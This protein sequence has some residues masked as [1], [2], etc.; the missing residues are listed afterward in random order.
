VTLAEARRLSVAFGAQLAVDGVD[1]EVGRGEVVGLLG[2]N[3]AGKTTLIRALLGL[4]RPSGGVAGLFGSPPTRAARRR[5]GYV[6]QHL[7]LYA[8]LSV[9]ENWAFVGAV[10]GLGGR[11]LPEG[12]STW[13]DRPLAQLPL[14]VQRRVAFAVALSHAPELLVLDEPTSGVGPLG[15]ARLWQA[16]RAAADRGAGVLVTTHNMEEAEQCDRLAILVDGS[17]AAAGTVGAVIGAARV[18]EVH[19]ADWH[20]AFAALEEAGLV[21]QL[22]GA[23]LRVGAT[24]PTVSAVLARTGLDARVTD[25]P[26]TLEEAFVSLISDRSR[27]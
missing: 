3:G 4:V 1:L 8:D 21:V 6:A 18:A 14:G 20:R 11:P 17:V 26:A 22:R 25:A 2:A 10:F 13:S 24:T 27:C 15:A 16:V 9:I 7:G 5:V 12:F 23:V 19:C